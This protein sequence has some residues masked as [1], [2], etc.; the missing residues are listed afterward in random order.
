MNDFLRKYNE[1]HGKQD[2]AK[3]GQV[4]LTELK[5][6]DGEKAIPDLSKEQPTLPNFLVDQWKAE[7]R[8]KNYL[9]NYRLYLPDPEGNL[10]VDF[11]FNGKRVRKTLGTTDR[12]EA[13]RRAVE[14]IKLYYQQKEQA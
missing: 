9:K 3:R 1:I 11:P 6:E 10:Y 7:G 2:E 4:D 14:L 5:V 8:N 12:D 13:D